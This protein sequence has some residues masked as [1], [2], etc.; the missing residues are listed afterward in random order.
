[1]KKNSMTDL[2]FINN[3]FAANTGIRQN[4]LQRIMY[5]VYVAPTPTPTPSEEDASSRSSSSEDDDD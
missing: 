1:M 3:I 2:L 4:E 5:Q